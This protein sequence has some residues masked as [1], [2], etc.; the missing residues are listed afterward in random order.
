MDDDPELLQTAAQLLAR[1]F[2]VATYGASFNRL[3]A[4]REHRPDLVLMDVNMPLIPG[5]E[6][7]R[8]LKDTP[9]LAGVPVFLFSNND[10]RS[11]KQLAARC[12]AAG[13]IP[14]SELGSNFAAHVSRRLRAVKPNS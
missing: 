6:V 2:D 11:L 10:E 3:N 14:K 7:V 12:G 13:Y 8:L 5:D 4:V 9:E 1:E